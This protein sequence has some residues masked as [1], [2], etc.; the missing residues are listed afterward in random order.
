[1][2]KLILFPLNLISIVSFGQNVGI[3]TA[4]PG[5]KLEVV[6]VSSTSANNSLLI[7]NSALDTMFRVRNDGTVFIGNPAIP[8]FLGYRFRVE[9]GNKG[10]LFIENP[11]LT[12][13]AT[14]RIL[15]GVPEN[16]PAS[17]TA[18][19]VEASSDFASRMIGFGGIHATSSNNLRPAGEFISAPSG[20]AIQANGKLQLTGI[21]EAAGK[22]LTSDAFGNA[23]WNTL[24]GTHNHFGEMW[25][26][27]TTGI[28]LRIINTN[29]TGFQ[30]AALVGQMTGGGN[31]GTRGVEGTS[32]STD[33]IGVFGSNNSVPTSAVFG[34]S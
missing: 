34:N 9:S 18:L 22:V 7:R 16:S 33:G 2:K 5:A 14:V 4:A 12:A 28:G 11:I 3:G 27:D 25:T 6:G 15:R 26:G 30:A 31:A 10:S 32:N 20:Y 23:T 8:D 19:Y 21:S 29:S 24:D 13:N 17:T 1:M